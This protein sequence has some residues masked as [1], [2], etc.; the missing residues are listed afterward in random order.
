[1]PAVSLKQIGLLVTPLTYAHLAWGYKSL[2]RHKRPP[3]CITH[4][5]DTDGYSISLDLFL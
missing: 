3:R 2:P 4:I 1:M 5:L